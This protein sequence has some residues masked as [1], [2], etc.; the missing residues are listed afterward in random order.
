MGGLRIT[1]DD[2][3]KKSDQDADSPLSVLIQN[4]MG[5]ARSLYDWARDNGR[6]YLVGNLTR[7]E[8]QERLT[9]ARIKRYIK[10][11]P[12]DQY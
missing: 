3:G 2:C 7:N 11:N 5:E 1:L 10:R 4:W 6:A 12:P 9:D 8:F